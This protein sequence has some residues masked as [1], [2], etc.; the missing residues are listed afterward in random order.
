MFSFFSIDEGRQSE[1]ATKNGDT[2]EIEQKDEHEPEVSDSMT[3]LTQFCMQ[4]D[5]L[6]MKS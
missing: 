4:Y 1:E 3:D 5:I 6:V 2:D